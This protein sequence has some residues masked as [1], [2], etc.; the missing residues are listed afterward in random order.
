MEEFQMA[1]PR[2]SDLERE[3]ED[4]FIGNGTGCA[5]EDEL[6]HAALLQMMTAALN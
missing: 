5:G 4:E 1:R 3:G 2:A 6:E